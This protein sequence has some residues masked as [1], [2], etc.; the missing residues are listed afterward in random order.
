MNFCSKNIFSSKK[1]LKI[2]WLKL[3]VKKWLSNFFLVRTIIA[4]K[5][6]CPKEIVK[7]N[8]LIP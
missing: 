6:L 1:L 7:K 3:L 8:I 2:L 5:I 4:K